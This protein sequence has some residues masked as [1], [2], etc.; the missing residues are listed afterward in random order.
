MMRRALLR[1]PICQPVVP[2][3]KTMMVAI[4]PAITAAAA[5]KTVAASTPASGLVFPLVTRGRR[6]CAG[7]VTDGSV[8]RT[9]DVT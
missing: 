4:A 9:R 3:T 1:A 5:A 2:A 7:V 8:C 6:C